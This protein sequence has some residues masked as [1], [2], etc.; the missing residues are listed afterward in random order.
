MFRLTAALVPCLILGALTTLAQAD[1]RI[2]YTRHALKV[3][4]HDLDLRRDADRQ[5][6]QDR[7]T[8]AADKVCGGRPDRSNRYSGDELKLLIP[9]YDK[10]HADA[11]RGAQASA[12]MPLIAEIAGPRTD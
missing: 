3:D 9:A 4:V 2:V 1:P 12:K 11:M 5:V 7:I 10:C 6:L 8:D